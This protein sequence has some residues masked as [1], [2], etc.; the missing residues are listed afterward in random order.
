[1]PCS[2]SL[3]APVLELGQTHLLL[4]LFIA[5]EPVGQAI[6]A[7]NLERKQHLRI[8][9][10]SELHQAAHFNPD[11]LTVA[12][13][14]SRTEPKRSTNAGMRRVRLE[15]V[16]LEDLLCAAELHDADPEP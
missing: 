2:L 4:A 13:N 8:F 1:M 5:G 9:I 15:R 7:G 12:C 16:P 14:S 3:A 10:R 6:V 11:M